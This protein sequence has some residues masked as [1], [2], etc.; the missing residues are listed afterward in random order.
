MKAVI[1]EIVQE[2]LE[3][4]IAE[5]GWECAQEILFEILCNDGYNK[6]EYGEVAHVFWGAALDGRKMQSNKVIALLYHRLG[7]F[8]EYENELWSI[9]CKLK[10]LDYLSD[11]DP[12]T[13]EEILRELEENGQWSISKNICTKK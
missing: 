1:E 12:M 13:D 8:E 11:Y 10:G 4:V 2:R 6:E 7:A 9:V 5:Y 3:A